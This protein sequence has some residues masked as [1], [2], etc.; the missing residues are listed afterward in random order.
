MY[1]QQLTMIINKDNNKISEN[2]WKKYC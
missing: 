1:I 2:C